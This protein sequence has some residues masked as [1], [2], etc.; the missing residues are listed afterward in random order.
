MSDEKERGRTTEMKERERERNTKLDGGW[1]ID[2]ST[3]VIIHTNKTSA[4]D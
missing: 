4:L 2:G 1:W 3:G